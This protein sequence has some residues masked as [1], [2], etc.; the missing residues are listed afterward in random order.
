[1]RGRD[2]IKLVRDMPVVQVVTGETG[3]LRDFW[4]AP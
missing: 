3:K 1:V 2:R 4:E